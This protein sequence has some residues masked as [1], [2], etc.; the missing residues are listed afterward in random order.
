[1][2]FLSATPSSQV[3]LWAHSCV[4]DC[5]GEIVRA[6]CRVGESV[7]GE[8]GLLER[9]ESGIGGYLLETLEK[10]ETVFESNQESL[11]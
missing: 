1:M 8:G 7:G 4:C 6:D 3:V 5:T 9:G 10:L 11:Y 2:A